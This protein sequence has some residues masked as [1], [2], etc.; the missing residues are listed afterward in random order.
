L[1]AAGLEIGA[2]VLRE[3]KMHRVGEYEIAFLRGRLVDMVEDGEEVR[4]LV[5]LGG[6]PQ[7]ES[8]AGR[9]VFIGDVKL[10]EV[11]RALESRG[12][13][14]EFAAGCLVCDGRIVVRR[15]PESGALEVEGPL[16]ERF[17]AV[18]DCVYAQYKMA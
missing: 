14:A 13:R 15:R 4:Q 12:L 10:T 5:P 11:R 17:Y 16:G 8:S 1:A 2:E 18:R 7:T 6:L 3:L 9:G